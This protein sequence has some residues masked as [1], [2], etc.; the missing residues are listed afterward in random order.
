MLF[1]ILNLKTF[2]QNSTS[3]KT[4]FNIKNFCG[5]TMGVKFFCTEKNAHLICNIEF[6]ETFWQQLNFK[7]NFFQCQGFCEET[8]SKEQRKNKRGKNQQPCFV[9]QHC[10]RAIEIDT[11][12]HRTPDCTQCLQ[13]RRTR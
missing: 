8:A 6:E 11:K 4:S 3:N 13:E 1:V 9:G 7:Q 2:W 10:R 5:E 12:C